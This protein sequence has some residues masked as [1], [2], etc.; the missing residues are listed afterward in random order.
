[1]PAGMMV[2]A[3]DGMLVNLA[4]M[5][6]TGRLRHD[7]DRGRLVPFPQLRV[8]ALTARAGRAMTGAILGR[9]S[10]GEQTLLNG[11]RSD[12]RTCSPAASP[13]SIETFPDMAW[14]QRSCRGRAGDRP[15]TGGHLPSLPRG[16][17][18]GLAARRV[19]DELAERPVGEEGR[20]APGPGHRAER[21][22]ARPGRDR[23]GLRDLHHHHH[24]ARPRGRAR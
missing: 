8:V 7:R 20:P 19:P 9:A 4:D 14:S 6:R 17:G 18:P 5:P 22:H 3:A 21:H 16:T 11:S 10:D 12:A 13:A 2:L 23:A 1:M 24:S 15:G